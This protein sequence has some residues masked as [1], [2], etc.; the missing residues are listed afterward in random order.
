MTGHDASHGH[1]HHGHH[2]HGDG[3]VGSSHVSQPVPISDTLGQHGAS[4]H[5]ATAGPHSGS[6][7]PP[8]H[9]I[10]FSGSGHEWVPG[11]SGYIYEYIDGQY[12]GNWVKG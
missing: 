4:S 3:N 6:A 10:Q 2:A 1:D 8:P 9:D 7:P 11:S 12:T 5:I